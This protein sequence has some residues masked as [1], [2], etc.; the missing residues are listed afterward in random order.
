MLGLIVS[1]MLPSFV[2]AMYD[3]GLGRFC[4]RDP[5]G[6]AD[7]SNVYFSRLSVN[8]ADPMGLAY[9]DLD[10]S[11]A[12]Q[13]PWC[14]VGLGYKYFLTTNG[15]PSSKP[16]DY[17]P[18]KGLP[19]NILANSDPDTYKAECGCTCCDP[20]QCNGTQKVV[21]RAIY[22]GRI[23]ISET[24]IQIAPGRVGASLSGTYGHEQRHVRNLIDGANSAAQL[25]SQE[26]ARAGCLRKEDCQARAAQIQYMGQIIMDNWLSRERDHGKVGG[27][28]PS[29]YE[30]KEG[31]MYPPLGG[32]MPPKPLCPPLMAVDALK[33]T[34]CVQ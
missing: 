30:P 34:P 31:V 19:Q 4:S 27:R 2:S 22:R 14:K 17:D 8:G 26:E 12:L 29:G 5:I 1:L 6:Y 16:L 24:A 21:C 13:A 15:R 23:R 10:P 7:G 11:S 18:I 20:N 3:P 33:T 32:G 28:V 9:T 25:M